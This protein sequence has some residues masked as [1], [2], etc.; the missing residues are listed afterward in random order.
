MREKLIRQPD[1][2]VLGGIAAAAGLQ[3]R[4]ILLSFHKWIP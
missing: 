1:I 2:Q 4:G 3:G